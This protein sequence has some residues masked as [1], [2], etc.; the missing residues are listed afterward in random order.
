LSTSDCLKD[1][2]HV[3]SESGA[4]DEGSPENTSHH[5]ND[6]L[7][8][9]PTNDKGLQAFP[10]KNVISP[11]VPVTAWGVNISD[12]IYSDEIITV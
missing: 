11:V 5:I 12:I 9:P 8:V 10:T 4:E 6:I 3:I 1:P 7:E 2:S